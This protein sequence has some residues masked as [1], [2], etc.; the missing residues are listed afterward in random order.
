[1]VERFSAPQGASVSLDSAALSQAIKDNFKDI[2]KDKNRALDHR[3]IME[4][5]KR[6][7]LNQEQ[8]QVAKFLA[9]NV[10]K[11]GSLGGSPRVDR[12]DLKELNRLSKVD[13]D[14]APDHRWIYAK[15]IARGAA[16]GI[17][18]TADNEDANPLL[19][20]V[21]GGA[22]GA[23][24]A[25]RLAQQADAQFAKD[26]NTKQAL[27]LDGQ[28]KLEHNG[29]PQEDSS[30]RLTLKLEDITVSREGLNEIA[31]KY[32]PVI[33]L[34]GDHNLSLTELKL[35]ED[36]RVLPT[37]LSY[38]LHFM[39]KNYY[40]MVGLADRSQDKYYDRHG[41][42]AAD[43]SVMVKG[44]EPFRAN[45]HGVRN[46]LLVGG[47]CVVGGVMGAFIGN[48]PGAVAGCAGMSA[49]AYAGINKY[50]D[51]PEA[52]N[53][54]TSR[55]YDYDMRRASYDKIERYIKPTG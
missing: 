44:I 38:D 41:V 46:T 17:Q 23:F 43:L 35:A 24:N 5:G 34:N 15:G 47:A 51:T 22:V 32:L 1:M 26:L 8:T 53:A 52:R 7:G 55:R 48:A 13:P 27:H 19:A 12:A 25:K 3:E 4:Y 49:V 37:N 2:D 45:D 6:P 20:A 30:T 21:A 36:A 29:K 50:M 14:K 16:F 42:S 39:T 40:S 18:A 33:D 10:Y 9:E 31:T 11:M 54:E 28:A